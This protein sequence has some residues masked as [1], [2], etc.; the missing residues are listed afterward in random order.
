MKVAT[1]IKR[2]NDFGFQLILNEASQV[3]GVN[4]LNGK[5]I[6]VKK[7]FAK[8]IKIMNEVEEKKLVNK[9]IADCLKSNSEK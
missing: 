9:V 1:N 5:K 2:I 6:L 4:L 3:E 7:R 8:A